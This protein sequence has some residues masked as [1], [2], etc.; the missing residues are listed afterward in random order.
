M[1]TVKVHI[2]R[3]DELSGT[4]QQHALDKWNEGADYNWIGEARDTVKAFEEE[5]HVELRSWGFNRWDYRYDLRTGKIDDDVLALKGN[6]ARA[7]F[8]KKCG[9]L[10]LTP[11]K[12]YFTHHQGKLIKAISTDSRVYKSKV[13]FDRCYDGTCPWTGVFCDNVML[14]PIAYFCFG[15]RWDENL[16]KRVPIRMS[17]REDDSNTVESILNECCDSFL[18][19]LMEDYRDQGKIEHFAETCEANNFRFTED[20]EMWSGNYE[21]KEVKEVA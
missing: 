12:T 17:K 7:W 5:F 16:K 19:T 14:D 15:V 10:L 18:K 4:A 6:R 13:F 2:Y 3:F 8:W 1:E 9:H 11:R 20:G 21:A